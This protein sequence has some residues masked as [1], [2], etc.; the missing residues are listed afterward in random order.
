MSVTL[1]AESHLTS[2]NRNCSFAWLLRVF[3]SVNIIKFFDRYVNCARVQTSVS[4]N[5]TFIVDCIFNLFPTGVS[6]PV[7]REN[8]PFCFVWPV[9]THSAVACVHLSRRNCTQYGGYIRVYT[10]S[11]PLCVHAFVENPYTEKAVEHSK[12]QLER[13]PA[14]YQFK[15]S[16]RDE[17]NT[18]RRSQY[19]K[20]NNK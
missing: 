6:G 18:G 14:R 7:I 11:G 17:R 10:I 15:R 4:D 5:K 8:F 19:E 9:R 12:K 20:I 1:S 13:Y 2:N 3:L 16:Q